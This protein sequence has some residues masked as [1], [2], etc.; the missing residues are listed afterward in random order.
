MNVRERRS[1]RMKEA[2]KKA[3]EYLARDKARNLA[4][5]KGEPFS[6]PESVKS[7][8]ESVKKEKENTESVNNRKRAIKNLPKRNIEE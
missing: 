2:A 5:L 8:P 4:K 1:Q 6:E 7:E 3:R